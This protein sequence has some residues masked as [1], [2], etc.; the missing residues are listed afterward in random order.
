[1]EEIAIVKKRSRVWPILIAL[2]V[3][4]LITAAVF[5]ATDGG[6]LMRE[7]GVSPEPTPGSVSGSPAG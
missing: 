5:F 7:I 4:A 6:S 2:V 3:L 1:M